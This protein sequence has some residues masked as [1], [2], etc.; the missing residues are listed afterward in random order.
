[1]QDEKLKRIIS[2]IEVGIKALYETEKYKSYLQTM[3]KF[4]QYSVNNT[5][6]ISNQCPNATLVAGFNKWKKDFGRMVKKGE[7]AIKIIAPITNISKK[8]LEQVAETT[9]LPVFDEQIPLF[10]V[11]SV[12]DVSQTEGQELPTL[13]STL[14]GSVEQYS[15]F[16]QALEYTSTIP[17]KIENIDSNLDGYYDLI[18]KVIIIRDGMSEMQTISSI[19][20]EIA[21][22][23][24]HNYEY[25]EDTVKKTRSTEEIE[26]ESIS[27]VVCN[28]YGIDTGNNS[29]GYIANWSKDKELSELKQSLEVISKTSSEIITSIDKFLNLKQI[30]HNTPT[31]QHKKVSVLAELKS[32]I[33][34]PTFQSVPKTTKKTMDKSR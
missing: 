29:F 32:H 19:I 7:K 9:G 20:H 4:H 31:T 15:K 11:V 24:L 34:E 25:Q 18:D 1:M 10:R 22:S 2:S 26:A 5:I 21:H 12:F 33:R 13:V 8:E 6:L 28:Y 14:D 23:R 27:Y 16:M 17:I 30:E 3:S